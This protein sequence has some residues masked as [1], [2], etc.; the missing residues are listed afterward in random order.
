MRKTAPKDG[1][2]V[3]AHRHLAE[4]KDAKSGTALPIALPS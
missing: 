3:V 4:A 2:C 1:L